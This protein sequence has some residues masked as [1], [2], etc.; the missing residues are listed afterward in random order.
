MFLNGIEED[1]NFL[2]EIIWNFPEHI[3]YYLVLIFTY[4]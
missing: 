1:Y 2:K 3:I 4:I